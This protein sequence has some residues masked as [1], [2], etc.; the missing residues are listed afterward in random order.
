MIFVGTVRANK[1]EIPAE[2]TASLWFKCLSLY[3]GDDDDFPLLK[4]PQEPKRKLL[5]LLSQPIPA[6]SS[7]PE[8]IEFY[9]T[10][11]GAVDTFDQMCAVT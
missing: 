11:N 6:A 1:K 5:L 4:Y 8:I 10:T 2:M 3:K 7:K 9:N